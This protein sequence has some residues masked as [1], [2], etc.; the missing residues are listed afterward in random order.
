M[1]W[2][3][4]GIIYFSGPVICRNESQFNRSQQIVSLQDLEFQN[5]FFMGKGQELLKQ[6][7]FTFVT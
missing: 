4:L 3:K 6:C 2:D 1:A 7:H 5:D